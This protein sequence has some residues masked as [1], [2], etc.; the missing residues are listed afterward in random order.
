MLLFST[1]HQDGKVWSSG[2]P[3][4]IEFYNSAQGGVNTLDQMWSDFI[5]PTSDMAQFFKV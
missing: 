1:R 3:E 2:K 5:V 4:I